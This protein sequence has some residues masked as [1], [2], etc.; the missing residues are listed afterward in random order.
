ML[1]II[2]SWQSCDTVRSRGKRLK[3]EGKSRNSYG[4]PS[5]SGLVLTVLK[6]LMS[7][8]FLQEDKECLQLP[9][10]RVKGSSSD[11]G[12]ALGAQQRELLCG[13]RA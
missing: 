2:E 4:I 7:L 12:H 9:L 6:W 11:P 3:Q 13:K 5:S 10:S 1:S 8:Y